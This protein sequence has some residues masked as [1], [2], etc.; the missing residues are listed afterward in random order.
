MRTLRLIYH[1]M[2]ADFLERTRRSSFFVTL[3]LAALIGYIFIPPADSTTLMFALGPWRGVYNSDWI[4]SVFG[5]LIVISLP[6][7]GFFLTKNTIERDRRSR[8]GQILATTPMSKPVYT[9]GKWLSNLAVL[10]AMLVVLNVMAVVMQLLRGEIF[11]MNYWALSAPIWLMGFPVLALAA[12]LAVL[13]E[14]IPFLS[15]SVG[16]VVYF[17]AWYIFM[18]HLAVPGIFRYNIGIVTP[19]PDPL[20]VT[21]L[22]AALQAIGQQVAPQFTGHINF[23]GAEFGVIP[24]VVTFTGLAWTSA[25]MLGRLAWLFTAGLL[26][27]SASLPFDRFDPARAT[28][29][30]SALPK[31]GLRKQKTRQPLAE[32]S[33]L[34]AEQVNLTPI[35]HRVYRSRF[36]G[37]LTAEFKLLVKG[38]PWWWY[39]LAMFISL[40]GLAGPPGGSG[41]TLA[42]A[43]IWPVIAWSS[44]GMRETFFETYKLTYSAAHP[45]RRQFMASWLSGVLLAASA[46]SGATIRLVT[47]GDVDRLY[48]VLLALLFAPTLAM[49]LGTWSNSSRLFEVVYLLWLF[50]GVNGAV[51]LDFMQ[52]LQASPNE[53]MLAAYFTLTFFLF[54]ASLVG[55]WRQIYAH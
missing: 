41:V 18:D 9:L 30:G 31:A 27:L 25:I 17:L 13:F 10:T 52:V 23:G 26:A 21:H 24:K 6:V 16:N 4:G 3:G 54:L 43:T 45:F 29:N 40:L 49:A 19:W 7:L 2:R 8:V 32:P 28:V 1:M 20:G 37:L 34:Q 5:I 53:F 11:P 22:L 36:L 48:L 12:A 55:R 51:P 44:L 39:L 15:G 38:K 33:F 14:S 46:A 50:T 35:T 42:L 47:E